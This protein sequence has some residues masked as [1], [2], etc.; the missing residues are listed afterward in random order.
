[1]GAAGPVFDMSCRLRVTGD[2]E[3]SFIPTVMNATFAIAGVTPGMGAG[4][5]PPS[6]DFSAQLPTSSAMAHEEFGSQAFDLAGSTLQLIPTL[7]G[8]LP[9]VFTQSNCA[10]V[11]TYGLGCGGSDDAAYEMFAIGAID[12]CTTG[13][14][15]TFLRTG[16]SYTILDSLPGTFVPPSAAA[17]IVSAVDDGYGQVTLSQP[18]PV[19]GGTT[20]DLQVCTNGFVALSL[21]QPGPADYSP[22]VA[23]FVAFSEPTIAG[24]WYDWSPN[25]SGQLVAEEVGGV[26]YITWD[27]VQPYN[28]SSVDTFQYQFVLGTGDCTIVY[29]NMSFSGTSG[30]HTPLFGYTAGGAAAP[31]SWDMS[32]VLPM[33]IMVADVGSTSL[34]LSSNAPVLGASWSLTSAG[35]DPISPIAIVFF[36]TAGSNPGVP[37]PLIGIPAPGCSAYLA[38]VLSSLSAANVGGSSNV[39]LPVPNNQALSG[40]S[41]FAQSLSLT[42]SNPSNLLTSNGVEGLLGN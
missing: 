41:L 24:P 35:V 11:Q 3:F 39:Q 8:Y 21:N 36:G 17:T 40:V 18:M 6:L 31:Q 27:A 14:A 9:I 30:W 16:N 33:G 12:I 4:T 7:P 1:M 5:P 20:T 2:V 37:L 42:L 25:Q 34:S 15:I 38:N 28:G 23:E 10:D 26:L 13:S 22:T 32:S 29:D 19:P